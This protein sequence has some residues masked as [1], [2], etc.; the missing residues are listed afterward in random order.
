MYETDSQATLR[1]SSEPATGLTGSGILRQYRHH[2]RQQQDETTRHRP[3][4]S[5]IRGDRDGARKG[6]SVSA[7]LYRHGPL[8]TGDLSEAHD[9]VSRIFT[10]HRLERLD[11]DAPFEARLD[12]VTLGAVTVGYLNYGADVQLENPEELQAY[13]INIPLS[14]NTESWSGRDSVINDARVAAVFRAGLPGGITWSGKCT[15]MCVKFRREELEFELERLLGR[16]VTSPLRLG[17]SMDLTTPA[18]QD[19]LSLLSVLRRDHGQGPGI[20][21]QPLVARNFEV[22]LMQGFLLAH[23]HT[24]FT[25]VAE[26]CSPAIRSRM[27]KQATDLLEARPETPFTATELASQVG[28][29]V[30]ALQDGFNKHVGMSPMAYLREV[31]LRRVHDELAASDPGSVT[32]ARVAQRWGFN[33]LGRF[34]LAYRGKFGVTPSQTLRTS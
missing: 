24:Y 26:G 18:S 15:Q 12:A 13:H 17:V 10:V 27:V 19:W 8:R 4:H 30:R 32:V 22:L 33:H 9:A 34:S 28:V 31:R 29:S 21:Q 23:A 20:T 11:R 6:G 2:V 3:S 7:T 5:V 14:G 25:G 1:H 16:P